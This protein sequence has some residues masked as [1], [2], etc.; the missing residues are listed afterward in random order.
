M[1]KMLDDLTPNQRALAAYM[2]ELSEEA[3]FAGWM[4]DLE[5]ALWRAV[6]VGPYRYGGLYLTTTHIEHL[7]QL[8]ASCGGWVRFYDETEETFVPIDH[9]RQV[10]ESATAGR[11]A[12]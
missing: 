4:Q 6:E 12:K 9:W 3:F 10:Y 5:F 11:E 2:S 7:K 1:A 8:S